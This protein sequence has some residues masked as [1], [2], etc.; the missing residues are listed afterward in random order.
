M[1]AA[2]A[3]ARRGLGVVWP[4][5][6]VGCILVRDGIVVGRGWT[7]PGGRPHAEAEALGRAGE[8]A[9]G[10][11]AYVSLEPCCHWGK[12][13]P[14]A[15]A[16]AS[17]GVTRVVAAMEDPDPRVSGQGFARLRSAGIA[18]ETGL[19]AAEAAE[20]NAGFLMRL[21][22]GRPLVTLK[23]ATT[24]DGRIATATGES[25]WI[26]GEASRARAHLMRAMHD[27]VM[28]GSNTVIVDDP[29]LTCRLGGLEE[30]SPV[31]IVVDSGLR[32]APTAKLVTEAHKVP[33]WVFARDDADPARKN[34]LAE[35]GVDVIGCPAGA[36]SRVDLKA[37]LA[38]LGARGLTRVL[39]EGGGGLA[40]ALFRD[41]LVD[42][43]AWI[44]APRIIGGDGIAAVAPLG[45]LHL[46]AAP[47]FERQSLEP[48]GEDVLETF[49]RAG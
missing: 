1:R 35:C 42:R 28:V 41:D 11:T 5:P 25:Q 37:A 6:S 40:A 20:I 9:R 12:S 33:T 49:R 36:A 8:S 27:S 45:L 3:L 15:D 7:Q 10:A 21:K 38:V 22:K 47:R 19:C 48:V 39:V 14:C 23:F 29:L 17:A 44:H 32:V 31:R 26:T 34:A 4:N 2:L 46:A 43:I 16:L 18:V 30:R 13:P 24:L